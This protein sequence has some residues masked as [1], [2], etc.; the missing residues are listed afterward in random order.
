MFRAVY[1]G[2]VIGYFD[3]L[4]EAEIAIAIREDLCGPEGFA[5]A[6]LPEEEF[7][8]WCKNLEPAYKLQN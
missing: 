3:T 7:T 8:A 4:S 5:Q 1:R 2:E 6:I